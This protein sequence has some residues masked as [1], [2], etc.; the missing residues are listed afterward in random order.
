M[1]RQKRR[2]IK[3]SWDKIPCFSDCTERVTLHALPNT[4]VVF[5]LKVSEDLLLGYSIDAFRRWCLCPLVV[6]EGFFFGDQLLDVG[7]ASDWW[8]GEHFGESD[9]DNS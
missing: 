5:L 7:V 1:L 6:V 8:L 3:R 4:V 2:R 9:G